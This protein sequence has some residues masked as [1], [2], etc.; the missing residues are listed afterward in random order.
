MELSRL[1]EKER[2]I[3]H[4]EIL[5]WEEEFHIREVTEEDLEKM[6]IEQLEG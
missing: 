1:S 5:R 3:I 6:L 4:E 2:K